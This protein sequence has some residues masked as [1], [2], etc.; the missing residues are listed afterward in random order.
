MKQKATFQFL[1][2]G[3][4]MGIPVIGCDCSV[5]RSESPCNQRLRPSGLISI[6]EKRFLIDCG[7]DIR[8]Q[9]LKYHVK[10]LDGLFLTHAHHDHIAGIDELRVYFMRTKK[11][12][13]CLL[14]KE[15]AEEV[16]SRY[17]YIFEDKWLLDNLKPKIHLEILE[18]N[19]GTV[20]FEGMKVKYVSYE[21]AKM[22][23]T[24]YVLGDFAYISDIREYPETI[25][26]DLQ[27]V[28][29]LVLSALRFEQSPFHLNIDEAI[30]FSKRVG[31]E[32]TW[33]THISHDL[34]HEKTNAYLPP[35]VRMAYDGLELKFNH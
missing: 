20:I 18:K 7:P 32:S 27:G 24:G 15:T 28:K 22:K 12:L 17:R 23:V 16:I 8:L 29:T 25:F 35:N 21:Q 26:E 9:A 31:A 1:G 10:H 4:S 11:P 5:C 33:L 6:G 30:A 2:T 14:S 3:G 13:S 19:R 34:D